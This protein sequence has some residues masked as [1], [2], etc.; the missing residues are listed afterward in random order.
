MKLSIIV[1]VYNTERYLMQC[2]DSLVHQ[3]LDEMEILV[4]DDG[5][6]DSSR[7]I[8]EKYAETYPKKICAFYKENGGQASAR[9][10]ALA[11]AKGDYLG[12]VDSDDWVDLSMYR[13]MWQQAETEKLDIVVCDMEDHYPDGTVIH[14]HPSHAVD[15]FRQTPSACNKIFRKT[16]V[17]KQHF[18]SGLWYEDFDFTTKLLFCTDRIGYCA[19]P[20]YHCHCRPVSTM[21]NHNA[22]KNLDILTVL[23]DIIAFAKEQNLF[24]TYQEQIEFM[25]LDH[26]LITSINRVAK[27]KHQEKHDVIEQ[28]R[29]YVLNHYPKFDQDPVFRNMPRNRRMIARLN[30]VGL[31]RISRFIL[32]VYA[33]IK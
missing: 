14:H 8:I 20:F 33:K 19:Q 6:T 12:F 24:Q 1:P 18:L 17:G 2:L 25:V 10:Y 31:Y 26:V 22:P 11:R 32:A 9:N 23:D 28:L 15:K 27:Q 3:T 7:E 13:T 29:A 5:S 30:A 21:A 4:V 16:L